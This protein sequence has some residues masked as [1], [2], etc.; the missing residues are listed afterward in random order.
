MY[1][2]GARMSENTKP[3]RS[4]GNFENPFG[5]VFR[6]LKSGKR[7]AWSALFREGLG[8]AAKPFDML[9]QSRDAK[10]ITSAH[11]N[12][13]PLV[14]IVGPPRSGT[15]LVYQALAY[16]LDVS[17]P[18]NL[19]ALF[20]RSPITTNGLANRHR[21][22]FHNFYGQ[23]ARMSGPNDAFHIWNRWLGDDRYVTQT[24]LNDE[25]SEEMRQF[26]TAWTTK[27]GKPFLNKNNRNVGC[28]DYL[29]KQLPNTF[30]VA[31]LRE[32]ACVA[33]SL[34]HAREVVQGDRKVGWG[35]QCQEEHSHE[36]SLG[37]VQ[38]VCDQVR[39][40]DAD[41]TNRLQK[42]DSA[43]VIQIHYEAFCEDPSLSI[44]TIVARVPG[45]T[46]RS[47]IDRPKAG[48]FQISRSRLLSDGE[49]AIITRNFP[50]TSSKV[51]T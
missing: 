10:Q 23:T 47:G 14:L 1:Q 26:L 50:T 6:M 40:N 20:P 38:D 3:R 32:P 44:D 33:R 34:I 9:L 39:K 42:I 22:D 31:V 21:P 43:R 15:T 5:L 37:Y 18:N 45:L 4:Y 35:F 16:C 11:A 36:E 29:A 19:S 7:A 8:I 49:E 30:V 41:L 24:D 27:Y 28:V 13:L 46:L 2:N 25:Q 51:Q 48:A 12:S 17:Y